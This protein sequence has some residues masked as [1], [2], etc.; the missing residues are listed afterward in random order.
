MPII[1]CSAA[2]FALNT[3]GRRTAAVA[4]SGSNMD[5]VD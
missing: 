3:A 4:R 2:H 1:L 5:Q